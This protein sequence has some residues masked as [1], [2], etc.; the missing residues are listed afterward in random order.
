[1]ILLS[2][3]YSLGVQQPGPRGQFVEQ[4]GLGTSQTKCDL[5]DSN[6]LKAVTKLNPLYYKPAFAR[7][8]PT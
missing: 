4:V 3:K 6:E 8:R 2:T 1:M 7:V 5:V